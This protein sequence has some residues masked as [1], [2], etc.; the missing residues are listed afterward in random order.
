MIGSRLW[1]A[2]TTNGK[3]DAEGLVLSSINKDVIWDNST[4]GKSLPVLVDRDRENTAGYRLSTRQYLSQDEVSNMIPDLEPTDLR[5]TDQDFWHDALPDHLVWDWISQD[6]KVCS[7]YGFYAYKTIDIMHGDVWI[8]ESWPALC[9]IVSGYGLV[10]KHTLGFR[11]EYMSILG[12]FYNPEDGDEY[13]KVKNFSGTHSEDLYS[14][15][16]LAEFAPII[17]RKMN[18]PLMSVEDARELEYQYATV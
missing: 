12:F 11:S 2:G 8:D 10:H 3:A 6:D 15:I 7:Y 9:G 18:V 1:V 17:S 4:V 16:T 14:A 13:M 5:W